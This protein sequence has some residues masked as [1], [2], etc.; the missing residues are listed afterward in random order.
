MRIAIVILL[1]A[2][3]ATADAQSIGGM[4]GISGGLGSV[5]GSVVPSCVA[6]G[7]TDWSN[8]CD[9]PLGVILGIL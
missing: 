2:L 1:I 6:D 8:A 7:K 3:S 9:L 4:S 5:S